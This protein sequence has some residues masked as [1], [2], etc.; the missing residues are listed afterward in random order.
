MVELGY[1]SDGAVRWPELERAPTNSNG[2]LR[3]LCVRV[4]SVEVPILPSSRKSD[5]ISK[6]ITLL[7]LGNV[8]DL[9][10]LPRTPIK[11]AGVK[12]DRHATGR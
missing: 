10:L 2:G 11:R 5:R 8:L 6:S 4:A 12:R 3:R 9:A 1:R 7:H